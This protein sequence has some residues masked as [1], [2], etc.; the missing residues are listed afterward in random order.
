[1]KWHLVDP[2]GPHLDQSGSCGPKLLQVTPSG[3]RCT[4]NGPEQELIGSDLGNIFH[5]KVTLKK[6]F[7]AQLRL[8]HISTHIVISTLLSSIHKGS[9]S[10]WLI[11]WRG[12]EIHLFSPDES[13]FLHVFYLCCLY[14]CSFLLVL[15][16][17]HREPCLHIQSTNLA[18]QVHTIVTI[19]WPVNLHIFLIFFSNNNFSAWRSE[20]CLCETE[21]FAFLF[22]MFIAVLGHW[23]AFR[24]KMYFT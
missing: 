22:C 12:G 1:M 18:F 10:V 13:K 15:P 6:L 16:P 9:N 7:S 11:K 24:L 3:P 4:H 21:Y 19:P 2:S 17:K 8:I 5:T 23:E 20:K 14:W